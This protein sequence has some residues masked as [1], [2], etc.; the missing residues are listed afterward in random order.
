MLWAVC[1]KRKFCGRKKVMLAVA[2]TVMKF[3]SGTFNKAIIFQDLGIEPKNNMMAYLREE[4]NI[5]VKNAE[6][7]VNLR[8]RI[9]LRKNRAKR[10]A[11]KGKG[12]KTSYLCGGFGL[13]QTPDVIMCNPV[14]R[15][16][17]QAKYLEIA[18]GGSI[19]RFFD[20][21]DVTMITKCNN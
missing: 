21:N 4:D 19:I 15:Y 10:L 11:K 12:E 20:D 3:N 16:D 5:R 1:P 9:T 8:N 18:D 7:K 14:V 6:S 13:S 17:E 2:D